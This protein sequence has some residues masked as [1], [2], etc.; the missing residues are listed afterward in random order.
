MTPA[1]QNPPAKRFTEF[2]LV[3]NAD[4]KYRYLQ[5]VN[6]KAWAIGRLTKN[7]RFHVRRI[8]WGRLLARAEKRDG[9]I[10]RA[11]RILVRSPQQTTNRERAKLTKQANTDQRAHNCQQPVIR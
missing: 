3:M 9:E 7:G 8:V 11:V 10:I 5:P 2:A 6:A 4:L 1:T